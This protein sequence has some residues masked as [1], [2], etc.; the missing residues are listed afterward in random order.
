MARK[1][2]TYRK[3]AG[4]G[5]SLALRHSLWQGPDHLLWVESAIFQEQYRRFYFQDIEAVVLQRTGRRTVWT[6]VLGGFF[7]LFAAI[8][9]FSDGIPYFSIF[10]AATLAILTAV[11]WLKGPGCRLYLQTAVQR[12]RLSNLVRMRKALKVM[13]RIR[14]SAEAVQGPLAPIRFSGMQ[15][16]T[17]KGDAEKTD[18]TRRR[19][20]PEAEDTALYGLRLHGIFYG[21]LL[22]FGLARG[23]QLW[24]KSVPMAVTDMAFLVCTLVLAIV[25]LARMKGRARGSLLSLSAWLTLVFTVVHAMAAYGVFIAAAMRAMASMESP[26]D[27]WAIFK[28]FFQLQVG[29]HPAIEAIAVGVALVSIVL[30]ILG[31]IGVLIEG[32]DRR[33]P[34]LAK[35]Q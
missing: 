29:T 20:A 30:G 26:Y 18:K 3:L 6:L 32:R 16:E 19:P 28:S 14:A 9:L 23:A 27:N 12:Y 33:L 2:R 24:F 31:L 25:V 5:F 8:A 11:Q 7:F 17:G 1:P 15:T 22:L 35:P 34:A 10:M 21:L 4:S 13:D